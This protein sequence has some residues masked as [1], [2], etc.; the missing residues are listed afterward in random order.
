MSGDP[1]QA[2]QAGSWVVHLGL[3]C[4]TRELGAQADL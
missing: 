4:K 3:V 2:Q 1:K